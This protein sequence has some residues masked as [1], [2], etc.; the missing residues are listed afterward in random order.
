MLKAFLAKNT[1]AI[2]APVQTAD[3]DR[4][5]MM[6]VPARTHDTTV[7]PAE[8]P[9]AISEG[10]GILLRT[11]LRE[12]QQVLLP[13][14]YAP[15]LTTVEH[16]H[17]AAAIEIWTIPSLGTDPIT[18]EYMDLRREGRLDEGQLLRG[19]RFLRRFR[20]R[21]GVLVPCVSLLVSLGTSVT[22]VSGTQ[23]RG[24]DG[25]TPGHG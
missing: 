18:G 2:A 11:D 16:I 6:E 21:S 25:G 12:E 19:E 9:T 17:T 4:E 22:S 23:H 15:D 3:A 5:R 13:M 20:M 8:S 7:L 10:F 1:T 24:L 14:N